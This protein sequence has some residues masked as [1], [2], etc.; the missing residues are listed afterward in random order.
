MP[1]CSGPWL[2]EK[3]TRRV[4]EKEERSQ[5]NLSLLGETSV[6]TVPRPLLRHQHWLAAAVVVVAG[7]TSACDSTHVAGRS[8]SSGDPG[9]TI[10]SHLLAVRSAI[11]PGA[12]RIRQ[13]GQEP[14]WISSCS[15]ATLRKGWSIVQFYIAFTWHGSLG[16]LENYAKKKMTALHWGFVSTSQDSGL[17][18]FSNSPAENI[19]M[20]WNDGSGKVYLSISQPV[21]HKSGDPIP[22]E[23]N[24][25]APPVRPVGFCGGG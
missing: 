6:A 9:G 1:T 13:L 21:R 10:L 25:G 3:S 20:T 14:M 4:S 24:G 7:V 23:F 22:A 17:S 12:T 5:L 16:K 8:S 15:D 2:S 11:P 18:P 19:S